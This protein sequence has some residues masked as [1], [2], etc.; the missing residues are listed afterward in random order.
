MPVLLVVLSNAALRLVSRIKTSTHVIGDERHLKV[1]HVCFGQQYSI[2]F[3]NKTKMTKQTITSSNISPRMVP[4]GPGPH[5]AQQMN[6]PNRFGPNRAQ[7]M[8]PLEWAQQING[9]RNRAKQGPMNFLWLLYMRIERE[10]ER[11]SLSNCPLE[12][13]P[14]S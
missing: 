14:A 5:S 1:E 6:G 8:N 12:G 2:S 7:Q 9:P 10:R 4:T 13:Y 3:E 11:D